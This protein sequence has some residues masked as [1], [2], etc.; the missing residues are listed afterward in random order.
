MRKRPFSSGM[1]DKDP[2][3]KALLAFTDGAVLAEELGGGAE[4][5]EIRNRLFSFLKANPF[6]SSVIQASFNSS[7]DIFL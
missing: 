4:H 5:H 2:A 3:E 6:R 7:K 1:T